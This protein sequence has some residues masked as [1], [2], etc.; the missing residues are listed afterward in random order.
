MHGWLISSHA[1]S[2]LPAKAR[3]AGYSTFQASFRLSIAFEQ[4]I[5]MVRL[6]A[7]VI[8]LM[9]FDGN[10][11]TTFAGIIYVE[12][13]FDIHVPC[14]SPRKSPVLL[15]DATSAGKVWSSLLASCLVS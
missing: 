7:M 8:K 11:I 5:N 10:D 13:I 15:D 14:S 1:C 4:E 12:S 2:N 9:C 3:H 6:H